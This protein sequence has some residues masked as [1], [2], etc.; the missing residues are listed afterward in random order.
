MPKIVVKAFEG[1]QNTEWAD[2]SP[3][4][5]RKME[6][7]DITRKGLALKRSG[8]TDKNITGTPAGVGNI[9][10]WYSS[11]RGEEILY[12]DQTAGGESNLYNSI[13]G[14]DFSVLNIW[15]HQAS[16]ED[17]NRLPT[18]YSVITAPNGAFFRASVPISDFGLL[19]GSSHLDFSRTNNAYDNWYLVN[20]DQ[21]QTDLISNYVGA[22]SN[23]NRVISLNSGIAGM[24]NGDRLYIV[25]DVFDEV[26][27]YK[28]FNDVLRGGVGSAITNAP[29]AVK[30]L[31][32]VTVI[33]D[34]FTFSDYMQNRA[35]LAT[36]NAVGSLPMF[37]NHPAMLVSIEPIAA[38]QFTATQLDYYLAAVYDNAQETGLSGARA[39]VVTANEKMSIDIG[40]PLVF[41]PRLTHLKLYRRRFVDDDGKNFITLI[42]MD[43]AA[44]ATNTASGVTYFQYNLVDNASVVGDSHQDI[45]GMEDE[46]QFPNS[47]GYAWKHETQIGSRRFIGNVVE[48]VNDVGRDPSFSTWNPR[49]VF[50]YPNR[51][52]WSNITPQLVVC[53]DIFRKNDYMIF[54]T[55]GKEIITGLESV[56]SNMLVFTESTTFVVN[57]SSGDSLGWTKQETISG[58][59][60]IAPK[61]LVN[62]RGKVLFASGDNVYIFNSVN[63]VPVFRDKIQA[64]YRALTA[65]NKRSG[66]GV[67]FPKLNQYRL[68]FGDTETALN[69]DTTQYVTYV[70][71]LDT[72]AVHIIHSAK[73]STGYAVGVDGELFSSTGTEILEWDDT[74]PGESYGIGYRSVEFD[75]DLP[76]VNKVWKKITMVYRSDAD[77]L[78]MNIKVK[79]KDDATVSLRTVRTLGF[80]LRSNSVGSFTQEINETSERLQIEVYSAASTNTNIRIQGFEIEY[81]QQEDTA[82]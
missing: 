62:A 55:D 33:G 23:D 34:E 57:V 29:F 51:V 7:L 72:L 82:S 65:G 21:H 10:E 66:V 77:L 32:G 3:N 60:C 27:S 45:T 63:P 26:H 40:V 25:R 13:E 50:N 79:K 59:G 70:V 20:V 35:Y 18:A 5:A 12:T 15:G 48:E 4:Q 42:S 73:N 19:L 36:P 30:H 58:V 56:L 71:E 28:G 68:T 2:P 49:K 43:E 54:E 16:A 81:E 22:G 76:G 52:Y 78:K 24:V 74:T 64:D 41:N 6:N 1:G 37:A 11:L 9:F 46:G 75:A 31:S 44:W 80:P 39:T 67:Y 8:Y 38:G 69:G 17:G 14:G 53:P 61:S 47:R